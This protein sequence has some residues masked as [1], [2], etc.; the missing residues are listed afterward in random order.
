ML[1]LDDYGFIVHGLAELHCLDGPEDNRLV[2][3]SGGSLGFRGGK[4]LADF[5][6]DRGEERNWLQSP[7]AQALEVS[8]FPHVKAGLHTQRLLTNG[9]G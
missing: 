4:Q 2:R 1:I 3:A 7:D 9:M 8:P 6:A 5:P